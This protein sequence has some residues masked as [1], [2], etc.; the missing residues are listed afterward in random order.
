LTIAFAIRPS[1][2]ARRAEAVTGIPEFTMI[3]EAFRTRPMAI[4]GNPGDRML[5]T[6]K[7]NSRTKENT[8]SEAPIARSCAHPWETGTT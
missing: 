3:T 1:E 2:A 7:T 5:T 8:S 6:T 4:R